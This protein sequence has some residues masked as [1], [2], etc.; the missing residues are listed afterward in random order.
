MGTYLLAGQHLPLARTAELLGEVVGAPVSEG[1]L[2]G[3]YTAAAAGLDGFD[4]ALKS[5]LGAADVLAGGPEPVPV[6]T[7]PWGGSTPPAPRP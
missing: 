2:A 1:S 5:A 3:W 7:V 4:D 6:S